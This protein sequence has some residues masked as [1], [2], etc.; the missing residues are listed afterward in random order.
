VCFHVRSS[1]GGSPRMCWLRIASVRHWGINI[2]YVLAHTGLWGPTNLV[3]LTVAELDDTPPY[4][5]D[6]QWDSVGAPTDAHQGTAWKTCTRVRWAWLNSLIVVMN[7]GHSWCLRGSRV[8]CCQVISLVRCILIRIFMTPSDMGKA[9][10]LCSNV[11]MELHYCW[12]ENY[13]DDVDYF[14]VEAC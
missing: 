6:V 8:L 12:F 2:N 14:V 5:T 9:C 3:A 13:V 7:Y 10:S 11:V 4:L 1:E